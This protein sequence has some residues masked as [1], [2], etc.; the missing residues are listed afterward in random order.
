MT[1]TRSL[2]VL[3]IMATVAL[4][5]WPGRAQTAPAKPAATPP[6]LIMPAAPAVKAA[7]PKTLGGK[8][9]IGKMLTRDELRTCLKRLD[10]V[11]ASTKELEQRRAALDK[12]KE[13]L[14]TSGDALKAD[15]ADVDVKL[16]AVRD[17][18]GR[19]RAHGTEIEAF[20]QRLKAADEGPRSKR[21]EMA[22]ELDA[23]RDRLSKAR[24]PLGEEE[25]R[26][27]PT[28][29]NAV[30]AYNDKALARDAIVADWN[31]RNKAMNESSLKQEEDRSAWLSEC[32]N[33]PYRED[34]EI[35]IKQGK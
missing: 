32:A 28:Y 26:L 21:E 19:M 33:R 16:A 3:A 22:K 15:R 8:A 18:E 17:W 11:N 2:I 5:S 31:G 9:P 4:S 20:N 35:A 29:Q 1:P 12:E 14:V 23:E 10:G 25:A 27:V 24:V 7:G 34:D 13:D 6:K 30:K